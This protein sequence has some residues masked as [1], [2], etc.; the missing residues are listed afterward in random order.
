MTKHSTPF[1][2]QNEEPQENKDLTRRRRGFLRSGL[3]LTAGAAIA[4]GSGIGANRAKAS[5][6]T[7]TAARILVLGAG[8]AGL[9][10][11]SRLSR[12]LTGA[13]ITVLDRRQ[14]HL[15]QPGY[16]LIAAGIKPA[17]YVLSKTSDRSED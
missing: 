13:D 7:S 15:Y 10:C 5:A 14:D 6:P 11:V 2:H 8:A 9:A 16:T 12:S 3:A 4:T 17:S 1:V